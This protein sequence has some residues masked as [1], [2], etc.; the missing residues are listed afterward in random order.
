M[1]WMV[2]FLCLCCVGLV[3]DQVQGGDVFGQMIEDL[4]QVLCSWV[5]CV[6]QFVV[7]GCILVVYVFFG[8]F[9][10]VLEILLFVV[11]EFFVEVMVVIYGVY[12]VGGDFEGVVMLVEDCYLVC[13]FYVLLCWWCDLDW[14]LVDVGVEVVVDLCFYVLGQQLGIEVV[15]QYWYVVGQGILQECVFGMDLGQVFIDVVVV[16]QC[17]DVGKLVGI[18]WGIVFCGGM[19]QVIGQ[20]VLFQ[21]IEQDI[22]VLCVFMLED[23]DWFYR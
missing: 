11:Y 21:M 2:Q 12:C 14:V 6:Q 3:S 13:Q 22:G 1:Q 8:Y 15:V 19:E 5:V 4:C 7:F 10:M 16:V 17:D 9:Q 20:G 18:V 23:G